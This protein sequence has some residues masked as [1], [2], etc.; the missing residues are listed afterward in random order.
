ML[1]VAFG[2]GGSG[3]MQKSRLRS[4]SSRAISAAV[5]AADDRQDFAGDVA[6][7]LGRGEENI[8][9][10]NFLGLCRPLHRRLA[11]E[12]AYVTGLLVRRVERRPYRTRGHRIDPD[13]ARHQMSRKRARE[14]M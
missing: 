12:L 3:V 9:G 8:C 13:T 1:Y 10:S 5:I 14:G 6:G 11:A 2:H 4:Y 7:A